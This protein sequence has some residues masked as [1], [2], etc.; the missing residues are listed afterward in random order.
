MT[1]SIL[2]AHWKPWHPE[3]IFL[4]ED[5]RDLRIL[6][7]L[8]KVTEKDFFTNL[9]KQDKENQSNK[10]K[11][12]KIDL[13]KTEGYQVGFQKGLLE[14]KEENIFL[15]KKISNLL[16]NFENS[17][18]I[19]EGALYSRILKIVLKI[20]SYVIGKKIDIDESILLQN[21]KKII[22][23]D[24]VFLKKPQ[25][26]VH[27]Q[28][29]TLIEKS[30]KSFVNSYKWTLLYDENIDLNGCK[31][32]SENGDMDA[33]VDSRWQELCRLICSQEGY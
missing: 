11:E 5:K 19:F 20:S 2:E 8:D 21:I 14:S 9:I 27:P 28:N 12:F 25:L 16:L 23:K 24:G 33:T 7:Y 26:I 1:N 32:K 4:K 30:L 10:N 3:K 18:S 31:I 13:T 29:K 17:F 22:D 15:E 6:C